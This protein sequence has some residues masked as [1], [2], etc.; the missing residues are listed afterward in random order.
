MSKSNTKS[1]G[2]DSKQTKQIKR[3]ERHFYEAISDMKQLDCLAQEIIDWEK[4]YGH[5]AIGMPS[6][7]E[8]EQAQASILL[9]ALAYRKKLDIHVAEIDA[10][11][12]W[13]VECFAI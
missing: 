4:R 2:L 6:V 10:Y 9:Q 3:M 8:I 1:N 5:L 11:L 12:D 13:K 7:Y